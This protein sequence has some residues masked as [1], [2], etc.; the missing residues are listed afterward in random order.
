MGQ[1]TGLV[2]GLAIL[3]AYV[4]AFIG[5]FTD[6][7]NAIATSIGSRVLTPRAAVILAGAFNLLGG[8][9][10]TAVALTIGKGLVDPTALSLTTVVAGL[11][12]AMTWSLL[13]YRV[14]IPVSETH[15]LIGG[16][17]GAGIATAGVGVV[18]WQG[19]TKTL[20]AIVASPSLGFLGGLALIVAIYWSLYKKS[21]GRVMPV[22]R[23]LQ[24]ASAAYMAFSHG[25]NDAQK[26]MGVLAM[27]LALHYGW[28]DVTVPVWIV[29]SCASVA[30]VGTAYGGW[31]IIRTLGLRM[32]ALDPV[33]GFAAEVAG[34]SVIQ[35]ASELGIPISTTHA[36]TSSILG[37]GAVRRLSAVRWGV[38]LRIFLSWVMTLPATILLGAAALWGLRA[39]LPLLK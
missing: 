10:G 29:L 24:R 20:I 22:F 35:G 11:A 32:T 5:G 6:A 8:L 30:A 16:L 14:G 15:G 25:R 2:F 37:V 26:P 1:E 18:Q 21:R 34:A 28:K 38:T 3:L 39:V 4:Y 27:A 13:T 17:V 7:A 12:G 33:Q 19:L 23:H 36:I 31:R 9:S